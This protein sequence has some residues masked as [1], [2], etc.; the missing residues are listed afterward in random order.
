[1]ESLAGPVN[2]QVPPVVG[3]VM[4]LND[5]PISIDPVRLQRVADVMLQFGLLPARF[6]IGQMI[7]P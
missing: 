6:D 2:G 4:A 1:M 5:Y 3:A 7:G